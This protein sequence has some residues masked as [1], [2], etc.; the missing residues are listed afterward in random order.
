MGLGWPLPEGSMETRK[1]MGTELPE[2]LLYPNS[3]L[4]TDTFRLPEHPSFEWAGGAA[5]VRRY[6]VLSFLHFWCFT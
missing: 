2:P 1:E 5:E 3:G 6:L 4:F